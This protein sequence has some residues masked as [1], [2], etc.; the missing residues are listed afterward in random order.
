[1]SLKVAIIGGTGVGPILESYTGDYISV[2]TEYGSIHTK[3]I[4]VEG[5]E[6][7][8]LSRH[9]EGH[10]VPPHSVNYLGLAECCRQL[11]V[12]YALS[13]AAVGSLRS[14]WATGV[15]GI[16]T[17]FIDFSFRNIT[18]Y[19]DTVEH[20]DFSDPFDKSLREKIAKIAETHSIE[21]EKNVVYACTNGPRYETPAEVTML[22]TLG[23][24]VVGMTVASEAIAFRESGVPYGC[25]AMVTNLGAGL[26]ETPL[27][28]EEVVAAM[29]V[30]GEKFLKIALGLVN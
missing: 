9:S 28:H 8:F 1:M 29:N 25:I 3:K 24:D 6:V 26:S 16:C 27:N 19:T 17:D 23:G 15:M 4:I 2:E 30:M 12:D 21:L 18:K 5:N 22:R 13:S 7:Y 11:K 20:T 10:K 14:D